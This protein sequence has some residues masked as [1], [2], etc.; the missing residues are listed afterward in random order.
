MFHCN[1]KPQKQ[2]NSVIFRLKRNQICRI[3]STAPQTNINLESLCVQ[4]LV[5]MNESSCRVCKL[6]KILM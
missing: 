4:Y 2:I 6:R 3:D 5:L 1:R